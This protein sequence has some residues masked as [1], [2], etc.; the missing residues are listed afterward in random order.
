LS[1]NYAC[2]AALLQIHQPDVTRF[3]PVRVESAED[4][5]VGRV[6]LSLGVAAL[7]PQEPLEDFIHRCDQALYQSKRTGRNRVTSG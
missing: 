4:A 1:G 3:L 5:Q 2:F 7:Q 6:T